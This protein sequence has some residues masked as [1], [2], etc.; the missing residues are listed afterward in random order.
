MIVGI[1]GRKG[2]GKDVYADRLV[3]EHGFVKVM[4]S[5]AISDATSVID[6]LIPARKHLLTGSVLPVSASRWLTIL[7]HVPYSVY[8]HTVCGGD[9]ALAKENVEVRRVLQHVG[10]VCIA[11]DPLVWV[12][13]AKEAVQSYVDSG[14]DVVLTGVRFPVEVDIVRHLGGD[15]VWVSRP[16]FDNT[17]DTHRTETGVGADSFDVVVMN[18][19]TIDDLHRKADARHAR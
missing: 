6:P 3:S 8:L 16:G 18:D 19:G 9:Y 7:T 5:E 10:D 4:M 15:A 14:I 17:S 2:A 13:R 1:G 11:V 12:N